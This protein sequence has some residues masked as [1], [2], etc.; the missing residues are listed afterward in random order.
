MFHVEETAFSTEATV[1]TIGKELFHFSLPAIEQ[2]FNLFRIDLF[3]FLI[4]DG[5]IHMA[6]PCPL[7]R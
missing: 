3:H 5:F 7:P 6:S 2:R 4:R 1:G